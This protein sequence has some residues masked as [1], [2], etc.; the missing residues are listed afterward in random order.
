MLTPVVQ[1]TLYKTAQQ[2]IAENPTVASITY[3]LPNKHYIP[4]NLDFFKLPNVSPPEVAE[5]FA[6]VEAPR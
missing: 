2:I 4:V 3:R 1:A 6:P 5:V